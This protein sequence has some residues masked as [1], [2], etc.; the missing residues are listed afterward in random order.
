MKIYA[1]GQ[2]VEQVSHFRYK[3][4]LT[5]EDGYCTKEIWSRIEMAK[6]GFTVWSVEC[7]IIC[8]RDMDA[9]SDRQK[10]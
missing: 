7:S 3:G 10:I 4:S 9:D 1:D 2:Q 8:S 5:S 6:K